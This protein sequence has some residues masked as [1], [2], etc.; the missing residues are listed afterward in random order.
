LPLLGPGFNLGRR[1]TR[2]PLS[3]RDSSRIGRGR[4]PAFPIPA[5]E[6]FVP[7]SLTEPLRF[8]PDDIAEVHAGVRRTTPSRRRA[9]PRGSGSDGRESV[10]HLGPEFLRGFVRNEV[11][12]RSAPIRLCSFAGAVRCETLSRRPVESHTFTQREA[13]GAT[14]TG[15]PSRFR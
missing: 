7:A 13:T 6:S 15:V 12:C 4:L 8:P 2:P 5:S 10:E 11:V 9:F 1:E 3:A 14:R